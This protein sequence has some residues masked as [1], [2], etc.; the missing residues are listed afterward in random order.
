MLDAEDHAQ[1]D[2]VSVEL[3]SYDGATVGTTFTR[4]AGD[5]EFLNVP[6][7][8][9]E[10][11]VQ[12]GGYHTITQ[13]LDVQGSILGLFLALHPDMTAAT[14]TPRPSSVSARE[15]SIPRKAH[16]AMDK[17]LALMNEKS[18]YRGSI[19]QFGRAIQNYPEYYEAYTQLAVAHMHTGNNAS[20]EQALRKAL[21][22]SGEQY[23]DALSWLATLLNDTRRFIDAEPLARKGLELEPNSW[24]ANAELARS[25]L[26]LHRPAEAE[27]NAQA[28]SKL[29]PDNAL[30]YLVLANVHSQLGN[31]PALLE[32]LSNYLR[33]APT[34][35]LADKVRAQQKQL[36]DQLRDAQQ[37]LPPL[38]PKSDSAQVAMD[39]VADTPPA[40]VSKFEDSST[41]NSGG[42]EQKPVLWPPT[43][44][45]AALPPVVA[46]V[47]CPLEEVL[48][49][50]RKRVQEL[51]EN[52]D[53]F[54]ATEDVDSSEIGK[55]GRA[56]RSLKYTFDYL[57]M[58]S[59]SR[60]GDLSFDESRQQIGKFNST[61][62]PIRTVGLAVGAAVFHPL[63]LD[64]FEM[65]CEG[66]GQWH[67]KPAWQL[68]FKQ[69]SDKPPR[70][71]A[72]LVDGNWFDVKLKG[73]TWISP[74]TLQIEHID[75]DLLEA[76]P[77]IRLQTE[78]MSIDYSGVDFPKRRL[79]LWL[80]Q[81]VS[82]Y[83]D[84][85]G[86]RFLN[87]HQLSNY[88]LFAVDTS[89]EIKSPRGNKTN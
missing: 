81:S 1:L 76:I 52:V 84:I 35:P 45:D 12:H 18:D 20:A 58:V 3:R 41:W 69:R 25:L 39:G 65:T 89:Q 47:S 28:A 27:K 6:H 11:I 83:I 13:R 30:L 37:T 49:G 68:L 79:Q 67:D 19:K 36:Q 72:V 59:L 87:R 48:K 10:I 31:A 40:A 74:E 46:G 51:L 86:H 14:A 61:P 29:Q 32:D 26:G 80:P 63:R 22:L 24:Q 64:D 60:G 21:E 73:R 66:L 23:M 42:L 8:N 88:L 9:Y 57:G 55:D 77:Q 15:L 71:Q 43:S 75:F 56:S 5:F 34:G 85:G 2:N 4:A 82:F 62:I 70:F 17:G 50:A 78:H 16:D 53:R 38:T 7:G 33:L 44:V 54:T